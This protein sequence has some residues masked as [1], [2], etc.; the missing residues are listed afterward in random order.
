[1]S[2]PDPRGLGRH[3][4]R[5]AT[6][7]SPPA[8]GAG[9]GVYSHQFEYDAYGSP[10]SKGV[11]NEMSD[12]IATDEVAR[13]SWCDVSLSAITWIEDGRDIILQLL[14]PSSGDV[15]TLTCRWVRGLR[16]SLVFDEDTAGHP[17]S[18]EGSVKPRDDGAW[19]V[20]FDFASTGR[21]SLVCQDVELRRA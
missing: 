8:P 12:P 20:D 14:A 15:L 6:A 9:T 7:C 4:L 1:M 16:T 5:T 17:L 2:G 21:L 10:L 11:M 18:W 3:G 19:D 13:M